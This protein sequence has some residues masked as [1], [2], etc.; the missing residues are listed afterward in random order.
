MS[1]DSCHPGESGDPAVGHRRAGADW[2]TSRQ[3]RDAA[4][5]DGCVASWILAFARKTPSPCMGTPSCQ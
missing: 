5:L 4:N 1:E 3:R 2:G